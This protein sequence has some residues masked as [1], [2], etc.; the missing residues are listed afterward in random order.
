MMNLEQRLADEAR[1]H[2]DRRFTTVAVGFF[3]VLT[4]LG[5]VSQALKGTLEPSMIGVTSLLLYGTYLAF[6]GWRQ[7]ENRLSCAALLVLPGI[8]VAAHLMRSM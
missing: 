3:A 6:Q 4:T 7:K 2:R 1:H 8:F 5:T